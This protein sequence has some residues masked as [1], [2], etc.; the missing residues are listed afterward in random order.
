MLPDGVKVTIVA[1]RGFADCKLFYALTTEL[2]FE[3]VIRLRGDVYVT[4]ARGERRVLSASTCSPFSVGACAADA[5]PRRASRR[6]S[7]SSNRP[8][9][10]TR[11]HQRSGPR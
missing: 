10:A 9:Q 3:Y 7:T 11:A 8:C 5:R 1:D 4:S 6:R 2:G